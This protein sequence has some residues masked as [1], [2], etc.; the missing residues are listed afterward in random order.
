MTEEIIAEMKKRG[1]YLVPTT[2]IMNRA[3]L[4]DPHLPPKA[5]AIIKQGIQSHKRAIEAGVKIAYG[6][7]AGL[8]PHGQNADGFVDL[9]EY[10]MSPG[11]A[12]K[13]ATVD[14]AELLG[15]DDRGTIE[16]GKLADIIAVMGNPLEDVS[17]LQNVSFVMKNGRIYKIYGKG[18]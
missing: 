5:V 17:L 6:T 7:D 16:P 2:P 1:T 9:V 13:T 10:G 15:T 14:A 18:L 3:S 12:I 11:Q 8:Y 4:Q